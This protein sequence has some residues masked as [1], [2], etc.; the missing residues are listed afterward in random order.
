MVSVTFRHLSAR[1]ILALAVQT[2]LAGIEWGGDVHVPAGDLAQA[3]T[4]RQAT[5]D[6][7][8]EVVS[9][10]SYY[11]A[12]TGQG[13]AGVLATAVAL[14]APSIRVWAGN[15]GSAGSDDAHRRAVIEDLQT[16]C[17]AA[18][19][20]G[21]TVALEYHRGTLTDTA[22]SAVALAEAV[23]RSNLRLYW[24][25]DPTQPH[26]ARMRA[27]QAVLPY[28]SHLHVFQWTQPGDDVR[29][30]PLAE[31]RAEWLDYLRL[32]EGER[33]ALLEFVPHDD[34]ATFRAE[35]ETLNRWL[36]RP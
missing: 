22:A 13:F 29:R 15:V 33:Y 20:E 6:A 9:Y 3:A 35:A 8:L 28:L 30:H 17:D 16:I 1:E 25:P 27:L 11:R 19:D 12:A 32:A 21:T 10:G 5:V 31:G 4:V 7:G 34:P 14:G 18:G 23:A 26:A 2:G 36:S 24:Q